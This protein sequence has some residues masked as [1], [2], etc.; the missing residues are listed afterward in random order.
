[1]INVSVPRR[2]DK[3]PLNILENKSNAEFQPVGRVLYVISS[4]EAMNA[5]IKVGICVR[6]IRLV[7]ALFSAGKTLCLV[8][9][10]RLLGISAYEG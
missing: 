2:A 7:R 8:P 5:D 3:G 4:L 6:R 10:L 9:A 1:M